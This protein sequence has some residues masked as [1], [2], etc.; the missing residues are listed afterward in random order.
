M[1]PN[2][3]QHDILRGRPLVEYTFTFW[4]LAHVVHVNDDHTGANLATARTTTMFVHSCPRRA[5]L[6]AKLTRAG[7]TRT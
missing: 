6:S 2:S 7:R 3:V 4:T 5:M 1:T